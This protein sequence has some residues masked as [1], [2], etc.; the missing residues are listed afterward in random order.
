L[1]NVLF[2]MVSRLN[3]TIAP[4]Y[5]WSEA[6]VQFQ[7]NVLRSMSS[8]PFARIAPPDVPLG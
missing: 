4:P 6:F 7:T 5:P 8:V 3:A 1:L 2:L